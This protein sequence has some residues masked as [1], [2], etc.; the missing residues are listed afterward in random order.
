MSRAREG[1]NIRFNTKMKK[2][3]RS[4]AF[5]VEARGVEP[6]SE[7]PSIQLSPGALCRL[8][9]PAVSAGTQA[10]TLGSH[11]MRDPFNGE[12]RMHVHR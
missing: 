6:L 4:K 2:A 11:F 10:L 5:L 9:F 12:K 8:E 1:F 3:L 7:N